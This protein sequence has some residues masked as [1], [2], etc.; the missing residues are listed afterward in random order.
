MSEGM[1]RSTPARNTGTA[2]AQKAYKEKGGAVNQTLIDVC[3]KYLDFLSIKNLSN[4]NKKTF[5]F[6]NYGSSQNLLTMIYKS[7]LPNISSLHKNRN[8]P[9]GE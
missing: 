7:T 9:V 6:L 2:Q 4:E 8:S 3:I 5:N 1:T